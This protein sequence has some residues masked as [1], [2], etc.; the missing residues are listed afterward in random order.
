[1]ARGNDM[2]ALVE[3]KAADALYPLYGTVDL[4]RRLAISGRRS[5]ATASPS[6]PCC[7]SA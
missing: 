2:T 3:I 7:S 4:S 6:I 5:P 1:M